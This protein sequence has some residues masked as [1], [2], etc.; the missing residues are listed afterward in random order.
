MNAP[1]TISH[2]HHAFGLGFRS[3]LPLPELLP[4]CSTA[5][6]DVEI[7]AGPV[8]LELADATKR[9]VRFQSAPGQLLLQVDGVARFLIKDGRQIVIDRDPAADDDD[10]RVFL[11][12]S[13]LGALLHQRQDLVLH[14]SAIEW[15]GSAAIFVG[16]SGVGKSTIAS[17]F[18]RRGH[19]ALTD[20]LAVVRPDASGRLFVHPGF[21]QNKLWLD[22]LEKLDLS[23]NGLRSIRRKI[24]KRAVPLSTDFADRALPVRKIYLLRSQNTSEFKVTECQGPQKFQ[25]IKNNTYRFGFLADIDEQASHFQSAFKLASQAKVAVIQRPSGAFLLEELADLITTDLRT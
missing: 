18:R 10:V 20:D 11:L 5:P 19:A 21:P 8:P 7:V 16:A 24:E 25:V 2:F 9:C 4:S 1:T 17:A 12:G 15:E 3:C 22:S 13:C 14:G 6:T 23:P